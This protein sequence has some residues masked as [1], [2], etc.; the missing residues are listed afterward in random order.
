MLIEAGLGIF[1]RVQ[2]TQESGSG[3]A[4]RLVVSGEIDM[5]NAQQVRDAGIAAVT[6]ADV[7]E[8]GVDLSAVTFL[9]STGLG[10]LVAVRTAGADRSRAVRITAAS[11]R[12]RQVI[13]VCGLSAEFG[14]DSTGSV[15][16]AD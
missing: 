10:A 1:E 8:L 7:S 13:E 4:V 15:T 9:D 14:L 2:L 3:G 11:P 6:A 5:S 12:V 16:G